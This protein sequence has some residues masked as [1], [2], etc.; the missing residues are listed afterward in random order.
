VVVDEGK[1]VPDAFPGREL[2]GPGKL[3]RQ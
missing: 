3:A 2:L 1:V